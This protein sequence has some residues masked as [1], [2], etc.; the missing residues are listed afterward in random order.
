M[1]WFN[2]IFRLD[3]K[4][5]SFLRGITTIERPCTHLNFETRDL[6]SVNRQHLERITD[7]YPIGRIWSE[8][9]PLF[10]PFGDESIRLHVMNVLRAKDLSLYRGYRSLPFQVERF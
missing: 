4:H 7:C 5:R 9:A 10:A 6:L 1:R 2:A 3:I 8:I